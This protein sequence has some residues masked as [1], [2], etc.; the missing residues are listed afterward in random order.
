MRRSG[1]SSTPREDTKSRSK[2]GSI[3][4]SYGGAINADE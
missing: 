3:R 1:Y 4:S 2:R